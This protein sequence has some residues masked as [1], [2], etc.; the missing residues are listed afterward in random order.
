MEDRIDALLHELTLEEKAGLCAGS[1]FWTTTGV[2]RLGIPALKVSDGPIGVRG[3]NL[4]G[5]LPSACFPNAS[6]IE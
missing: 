5:G 1:T 4:T 3:G 2:P 6:A